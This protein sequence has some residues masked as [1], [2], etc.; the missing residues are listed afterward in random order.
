MIR[1]LDSLPGSASIYKSPADMRAALSDLWP[2]LLDL[3]SFSRFRI[4]AANKLIDAGNWQSAYDIARYL[5]NARIGQILIK[6]GIG[7]GVQTELDA[8]M[9][10]CNPYSDSKKSPDLNQHEVLLRLDEMREQ[11]Q[12]LEAAKAPVP[13]T[14]GH[15]RTQRKI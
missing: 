15:K 12:R 2:L 4:E 5:S 11:I 7:A 3:E 1:D 6:G 13:K 9:K 8:L 10:R 14:N